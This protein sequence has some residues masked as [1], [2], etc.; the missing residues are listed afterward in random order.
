MERLPITDDQATGVYSQ[1]RHLSGIKWLNISIKPSG[2]G[3]ESRICVRQSCMHCKEASCVK[4]CPVGACAHNEFGAVVVDPG[5][6]IG[7]NYCVGACTFGV[8]GFDR[9]ANVARK[10]TFCSDRLSTGQ[11]PAC[12]HA[13]PRGAL[14]FGKRDDIVLEARD[15]AVQLRNTGLPRADVY[16]ITEL[17]GLGVLYL[18]PDGKAGSLVNYGLLEN[19]EVPPFAHIWG[20]M[21]KPVRL[22]AVAAMVLGLFSNRHRASELRPNV[23]EKP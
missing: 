5:K 18:L 16:G 14:I 6:C 9:R 12:A 23:S 10:C 22:L 3:E 19:P 21:F 2:A 8:M 15:R 11:I 20:Y 7:C 4:V 1:R 13:C 17:Q